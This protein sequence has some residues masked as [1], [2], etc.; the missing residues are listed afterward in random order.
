MGKKN[1]GFFKRLHQQPAVQQLMTAV[2][3]MDQPRSYVALAEDQTNNSTSDPSSLR[4]IV[5]D[6]YQQLY[7]INQVQDN[8]VDNYLSA[9]NF[10][11]MV[12]Q[13]DNEAL[14]TPITLDELFEQVHHSP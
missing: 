1:A 9:I 3:H 6:Y 14:I 4:A 12:N 10:E 2:R 13:Q 8:D 11:R 7:T 5:R